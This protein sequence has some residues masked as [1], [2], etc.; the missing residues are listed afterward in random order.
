[1]LIDDNMVERFRSAYHGAT[2]LALEKESASE[3]AQRLVTLYA[4]LLRSSRTGRKQSLRVAP[5][6]NQSGE[7]LPEI[8]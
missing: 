4:E 2:G 3:M 1:M 5:P 8:R 7:R 6:A